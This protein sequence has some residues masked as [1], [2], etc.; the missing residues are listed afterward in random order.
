M[1]GLE[2]YRPI[3]GDDVINGIYRKVRPIYGKHIL[4][5]NS[6]YHGGGVAEMLNSLVPLMNDAGVDAGWRI[7]PGTP[8]F[9]NVTKKFHNALQGQD[10]N[11]TDIKKKLHTQASEVFATYTHIDH[12]CVIVHDPQPLPLIK[13]YRKRQPWVWRC[14]IDLSR[15]NREL[16]DY[17]R[18]IITKYDLVLV[19]HESYKQPDLSVEQR[20]IHPAIDPLSVKNMELPEKL[21]AKYR[22]KFTGNHSDKPI[23]AQISRYDP[24][25]DPEGVIDVFRL[26]KEKVDCRL[27]L[28]GNTAADDPE[29]PVVYERVKK[30]AADLVKTGDVVLLTKEGDIF[31]FVNTL[32]RCADVIVQKSTREGFCLA[33]T[34]AL[35]KGT[36]VVASNVGGIPL[37]VEDG[38]NGFLVEPDDTSTFADRI[39]TILK[40]PK[41]R[42]EMGAK[43]RE[44]VRKKFLVTR[45]LSDYLNI[46]TDMLRT[47]QS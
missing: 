7:L 46:L 47:P 14:H 18:P 3:V 6:T 17:L 8:D 1:L 38:V 11:L 19:S 10:I 4:H 20:V 35:W 34:E 36:P 13:F 32:Q 29:G 45:L 39:V 16:W 24:W 37:Q 33:V 21:T 41:L 28:C 40:D 22:R 2:D 44:T 43:G 42:S 23:I 30:K 15:P 5:I 26:V 12:D 31:T 9:F 25:K 27:V